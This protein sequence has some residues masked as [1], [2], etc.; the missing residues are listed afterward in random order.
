VSELFGAPSGIIASDE[1]LRQ[2]LHSGLLAQKTLGEIEQQPAE[3]A[4]KQAHARLFGAE[5]SEKE[6]AAQLAQQALKLQADFAAETAARQQIITGVPSTQGR[7]ATVAD[8]PPGGQA[9]QA[10]G[11]DQLVQYADFLQRKR[12]PISMIASVQKQIADIQEKE[13]IAHYRDS[14]AANEQFKLTQAKLKSIG[15]TAAAAAQS[16]Q[17]YLSILANPQQRQFLPPG[18][19]GNYT[20]DKSILEAVSQSSM[21]AHQQAE[22]KRQ[23]A[24]DKSKQALR[25]AEQGQISARISLMKAREDALQ[26]AADLKIKYNGAGSKEA[27]EA[28][29]ARTEAAKARV[30][31]EQLKFAPML[32]LD[33]KS[34][35]DGSLH[36]LNDK[37]IVRVVGRDAN[38]MPQLQVISPTEAKQMRVDSI[39]ADKTGEEEVPVNVE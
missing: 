10:S 17:N 8:L 11:A 35:K 5:A 27:Q 4:L 21:D 15:G 31:A 20:I 14:Q 7:E 33:P 29:K 19:T 12:A 1:N 26:V 18:L 30:F 13:G 2:N 3:L 22:L 16:P 37:R 34:V 6:A 38:G 36:T 24:E 28:I 25:A 32:P 9:H 23:Q 39:K